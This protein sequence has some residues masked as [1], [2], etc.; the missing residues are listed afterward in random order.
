MEVTSQEEIK[1]T[2][3]SLEEA[4]RTS[5]EWLD[6]FADE[7]D[8]LHSTTIETET[9]VTPEDV[10]RLNKLIEYFERA[11]DDEIKKNI[12]EIKNDTP[13]ILNSLKGVEQ[14]RQHG[15]IDAF[16]HTFNTFNYLDTTGLSAKDRVIV[17]MTMLLHDIAKS[18]TIEQDHPRTS[19]K[20]VREILKDVNLDDSSKEEI[21]KQVTYHDFLGDISR[22]DNYGMFRPQQLVEF[23]DNENQVILH[24][25]IVTADVA[26]IPGLRQYLPNI[27]RVYGRLIANLDRFNWSFIPP[28]EGGEDLELDDVSHIIKEV[29]PYEREFDSINIHRDCE[30]RRNRFN[31]LPESERNSLERYLLQA[32]KKNDERFLKALQATGR[33]TDETYVEELEKKYMIES[34]ELRIACQVFRATYG[35]WSVNRII[36]DLDNWETE[37]QNIEYWLGEIRDAGEKLA[38]Q[39]VVATHC[40]TSDAKP[41]IDKTGELLKSI[42]AGHYEGDGVYVGLMGSYGGWAEYMYRFNLK[43]TD[44]IPI[45]VNFNYPK[46]MANV[47]CDHLD[48]H[49]A[50]QNMAIPK[51]NIEWLHRALDISPSSLQTQL[52]E[53]FAGTVTKYE[54][55]QGVSSFVVI[56]EQPPIVWG[57]I[58]RSLR[59]S[60]VIPDYEIM[61]RYEQKGVEGDDLDTDL[62]NN[63]ILRLKGVTMKELEGDM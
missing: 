56:T 18:E 58:A 51:G 17:R 52:L 11:T 14:Y 33:E 55:A 6:N 38:K 53:E 8:N 25:I 2:P 62:P 1:N 39:E 34:Q 40:T 26:S 21:E 10:N 59:I 16:D 13:G 42:G 19:G 5:Q 27:E 45:I 48:I 22:N 60:H 4:T 31:S 28:E 29:I 46:M 3:T 36:R 24:R 41:L 32:S 23:F 37:V 57:M 54:D 49:S 50:E 12:A 30:M 20:M 15:D 9:V 35:M 7:F 47:L 63:T 44:V 43:M 61:H